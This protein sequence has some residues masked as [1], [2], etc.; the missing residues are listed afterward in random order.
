MKT[1]TRIR[2]FTR[3][4]G[5]ALRTILY[6]PHCQICDSRIEENEVLCE[7]CLRTNRAIEPPFCDICC[8]PFYGALSGRFSCMN[9]SDRSFTFEFAIGA[10]RNRGAVRTLLHQFKYSKRE[11]L[12]KPLAHLLLPVLDDERLYE[13][14]EDWTVVPV[15]LHHR[16][17]RERG[18][19]QAFEISRHFA[20]HSGF[21]F[22]D[23]LQ[24]TI[25]T[26]SQAQLSRAQRLQNLRQAFRVKKS[27]GKNSYLAGRQVLLVDDVFTTGATTDACA[28]ILRREAGVERVVV[29]TLLRG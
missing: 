18:F 2:Q 21:D 22:A 15:P 25:Y 6:P 4:T 24:R 29:L 23:P 13:N 8:E 28:R 17:L 5:E 11:Y 27:V 3:T 7:D 14:A 12:A 19:N 16:R 20:A 10:W 9:C 26:T 1:S